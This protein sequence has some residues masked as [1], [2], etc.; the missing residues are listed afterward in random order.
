M[1]SLKV[2]APP[3]TEVFSFLR[4][5]FKRFWEQFADQLAEKTAQNYALRV[6]SRCDR[7]S[8]IWWNADDPVTGESIR[9]V[10]ESEIRAWIEQR[11]H[12][13]PKSS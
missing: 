6:W 2:S 9:H 13:S 10:S 3:K 4:S 11:H 5:R 1:R 7:H 12:R 8:N